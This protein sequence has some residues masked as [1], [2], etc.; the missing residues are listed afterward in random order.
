[1]LTVAL[2]PIQAH[3]QCDFQDVSTE[4]NLRHTFNEG[5]LGGGVSFMDFDGDGWDDLTFG[6]S[7]GELIEVYKNNQGQFEKILLNGVTNTCESKQILWVDYDNDGDKDLF[8]TCAEINVVLYRNDGD[9]SFTD[10][11]TEI[12]LTTPDALS[13]GANWAD[14]DRD[15]WLDLY[16]TYYG[17][18]RNQLYR[19]EE[20]TAFENVSIETNV[21]PNAK[22]AFCAVVFDYDGDGWEDIYLAND[23]STRNDLMKNQGGNT[24]EDV[25]AASQSNLAMDAMGT[26]ILDMNGDGFFEIYISNSPEGNALLFNNGNGTFTNIAQESGT[27]FNSVGWG[28]NTLDIDNDACSDLYVSGSNVGTETPSS[29]LYRSIDPMNFEQTQYPGMAGDT[30]SSFSNAIG[31]FNNDGR[32]DIAVSN[33]NGTYSQLWQNQCINDNHWL[34][35]RLEGTLSNRDAIGASA[36]VYIQGVPVYQYKTAGIGFMAQNTDYLHFGLAESTVVDSLLVFWPSGITDKL[37]NPGIDQMINLKEGNE[38]TPLPLTA[39]HIISSLCTGEEVVLSVD[40]QGKDFEVQWSDNSVGT[41]LVVSENGDY[42]ASVKFGEQSISS[43]SLEIS[44][45]ELPQV[46]YEVTDVS[47]SAP[48]EISIIPHSNSYNYSWSHDF[49]LNSPLASGLEPGN[50]V[51][52]IS[53]EENCHLTLSFQVKSNIV[54]GIDDPLVQSITYQRQAGRLI[55]GLPPE[56]QHKLQHSQVLSTTGQRLYKANHGAARV[57][58]LTIPDMPGR[59]TLIVQ[60]HF[61][62]GRVIKKLFFED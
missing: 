7:K 46:T 32:A 13:M 45:H 44:F 8:Y 1:M 30:L 39:S 52:K 21:D 41:E 14:F 9:L 12:G 60:L 28:V 16:I 62:D 3:G 48:G 17:T 37:I 23:R 51:V 47:N 61:T 5:V 18:V 53:S 58:Y 15:G 26:T 49:N 42:Q 29:A 20:G 56:M 19:N 35:L 24:F 6:T 38:A 22:P 33:A 4:Q 54:T 25:G 40:L 50:Y 57:A 36:V 43:E 34:K 10:V 55:I 2:F 59:Q 27:I 31:D 11:T